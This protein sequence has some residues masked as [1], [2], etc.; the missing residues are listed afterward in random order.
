MS[1][2]GR[3]EKFQR[4]QVNEKNVGF[5]V[6]VHIPAF[7]SFERILLTRSNQRETGTA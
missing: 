7:V 6:P 4:T 3:Y 5:L 1:K 2:R